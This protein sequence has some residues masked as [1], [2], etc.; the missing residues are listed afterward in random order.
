[1]AKST[2]PKPTII[3]KLHSSKKDVTFYDMAQEASI[4]NGEVKELLKTPRVA[5]AIRNLFI[6]VASKE[7]LNAFN[8]KEAKGDSES[9]DNSEKTGDKKPANYNT[10]K[11]SELKA[12]LDNRGIEY[13]GTATNPALISLLEEDDAKK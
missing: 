8:N 3:V 7:E 4:S 2:Q 11:K 6:V 12:E 1:M 13:D 5:S 9:S 10:M